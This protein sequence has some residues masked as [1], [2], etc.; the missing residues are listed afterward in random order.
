LSSIEGT[1]TQAEK[2]C[3]GLFEIVCLRGG[4]G[5]GTWLPAAR[6][7]RFTGEHFGGLVTQHRF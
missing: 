5:R 3:V 1:A 4:A 6:V 2:M 7:E